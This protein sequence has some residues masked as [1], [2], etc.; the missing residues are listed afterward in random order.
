MSGTVV[1]GW[2]DS[3]V[4]P[5]HF[6]IGFVFSNRAGETDGAVEVTIRVLVLGWV[7]VKAKF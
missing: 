7:K 5:V 1:V 6:T 4:F 2:G 3:R